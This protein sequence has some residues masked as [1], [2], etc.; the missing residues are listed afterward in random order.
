MLNNES[1]IRHFKSTSYSS[2]PG[3]TCHYELAGSD[4]RLLCQRQ[5]PTSA[6]HHVATINGDR[7]CPRN[8]GIILLMA[9]A[10][11]WYA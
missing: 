9:S 8:T 1:P 11:A 5:R 10:A 3:L 7:I 6:R 4:E 2:C